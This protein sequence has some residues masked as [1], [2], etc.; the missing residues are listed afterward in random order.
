MKTH[1]LVIFSYL[2]EP[3]CE[4][5]QLFDFEIA[6]QQ[7]CFQPIPT[8]SGSNSA[9]LSNDQATIKHGINSLKW[10]TT[11][12][13]ATLQLTSTAGSTFEIPND[14]LRGGGMKVWLYKQ[15]PSSSGNS[16]TVQFN[17]DATRVG[18]FQANLN[19]QGWRAIWVKFEECRVNSSSL[20]RRGSH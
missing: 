10:E 16:L 8:P 7:N 15:T 6:R 11:V 19:F 12:A 1:F 14:W 18:E 17:N 2:V 20:R 4:H 9:S 5:H 13:S 3:P